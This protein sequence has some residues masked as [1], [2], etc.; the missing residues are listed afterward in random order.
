MARRGPFVLAGV[1]L[2]LSA[3]FAQKEPAGTK[4]PAVSAINSDLLVARSTKRSSTASTLAQ[5]KQ[6]LASY[7]RLPLSFEPNQGQAPS[8]VQFLSRGAAYN[9]F[10]TDGGAV[11]SLEHRQ[12]LRDIGRL[13]KKPPVEASVPPDIVGIRLEKP[14]ASV[15]VGGEVELPGKS[16]YF[17]GKDPQKW[18]RGI[19]NYAR[20]RYH[21]VYPGVDLVYYG[22]HGQL[23][24][25]FIVAPGGRPDQIGLLID[26]ASKLALN[27][28]GDLVLSL[29]KRTVRLHKPLV[30][31][32]I[33][34]ERREIAGAYLLEKDSVKFRVGDYDH[35]QPLI[36]DPVLSFSTFFGGSGNE[37]FIQSNID[38]AI[39]VD[40]NGNIYVAGETQSAS[41]AFP[42]FPPGGYKS[43]C[44]SDSACNVSTGGSDV[45]IAKLNPAGSAVLAF[46]Y[47]G[48]S[49]RDIL[50]LTSTSGGLVVDTTGVY[51]S[52][53]TFSS[54]FPT[55][56]GVFRPSC[57]NTNG[58]TGYGDGFV[59]KLDVNLSSLTFST[60]LSGTRCRWTARAMCMWSGRRRAL[61]RPPAP[62]PR[63]YPRTIA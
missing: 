49:G 14:S 37:L 28:D 35:K 27:A 52:G 51:I 62:S 31:Q 13:G 63:A 34:G 46:T 9:L 61:I 41:F 19:P 29:G 2:F 17:I 6:A 4:A 54:D 36:I 24:Y 5:K 22:D 18:R 45:F 26:G 59:T 16:N 15:V 30:Y 60:Y 57:T 48:G 53:T 56:S 47:V 25:D 11:L 42:G 43:T 20:V 38:G 8:G 3:S 12:G 44:G 21:D 33:K 39:T 1:L 10:L 7:S 23:E 40:G 32:E 58:C 55:T 50:A